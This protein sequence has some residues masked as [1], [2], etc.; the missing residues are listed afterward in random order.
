[1]LWS[2]T[3]VLQKWSLGQQCHWESGWRYKLWKG[4]PGLVVLPLQWASGSVQ[5]TAGCPVPPPVI[6]LG[7]SGREANIHRTVTWQCQTAVPY[8]TVWKTTC[9]GSCILCHEHPGSLVTP[10]DSFSDSCFVTHEIKYKSFQAKYI[11]QNVSC[12]NMKCHV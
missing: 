9:L 8:T 1:M 5:V 3:M 4:D 10:T 6:R 12:V 2:E 11:C 7:Q